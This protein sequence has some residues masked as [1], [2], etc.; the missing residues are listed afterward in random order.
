M[1]KF[2]PSTDFVS[3]VMRD[4]YAHEASRISRLRFLDRFNGTKPFG[5]AMSW[6]GVFFGIVFSPAVCL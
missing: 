5:Y 6:C 4:V 3:R 1:K 2:E